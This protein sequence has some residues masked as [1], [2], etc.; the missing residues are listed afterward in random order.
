MLFESNSVSFDTSTL[1]IVAGTTTS[2]GVKGEEIDDVAYTIDADTWLKVRKEPSTKAQVVGYT[3]RVEGQTSGIEVW[4]DTYT[5]TDAGQGGT[6][7][8]GEPLGKWV[9]DTYL[10]WEKKSCTVEESGD[11]ENG[12]YLV[13]RDTDNLQAQQEGYVAEI[14]MNVMSQEQGTQVLGVTTETNDGSLPVVEVA[15]ES[16]AAQNQAVEKVDVKSSEKK[17]V[18]VN[19]SVLQLL[20]IPENEA[21]GKELT[22]SMVVVGELLDDQNKRIESTPLA[23]SIV[24]VIPD[25]GTPIV[26]V[27]FIDVRS[28]GVNKFSQ[29]KVIVKDKSNLASVRTAIESAG[30][31]TVSVAD[32]VAQI[33]TLFANFRLILSVLGMVA[34]SVAALGMFNTLTVSLLERT[35]EVGLMKA[36][37]MK[38]DEVKSLFL[39][40]SMIMGL[41]GGILGLLFGIVIGKVLSV[42]LSALS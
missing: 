24:G 13:L 40:E 7:A 9:K 27:P 5:D 35:R 1:G 32:T 30:F 6:D 20:N 26:Y 25:E 17:Q 41:Y 21:I 37:G 31:G 10:L 15:S 42:V 11:C 23:Y 4:G 38:S 29:T 36:M 22:L 8:E 19:R 28:M 3:K 12:S 16:A 33:D 18:V 14:S 39:T 34:L 2:T